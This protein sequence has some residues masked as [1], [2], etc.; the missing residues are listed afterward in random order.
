[1]CMGVWYCTVQVG[2]KMQY[3]MAGKEEGTFSQQTW[4]DELAGGGRAER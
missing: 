4:L 3:V 1:M 2:W